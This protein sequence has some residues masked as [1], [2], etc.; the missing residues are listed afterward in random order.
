MYTCFVMSEHWGVCVCVCPCAHFLGIAQSILK[1][2][3]PQINTMSLSTGAIAP[4]CPQVCVCECVCACV[5]VWCVCFTLCIFVSKAV[6]TVCPEC[7]MLLI[8]CT[9]LCMVCLELACMIVTNLWHNPEIDPWLQLP[10]LCIL[11]L[12]V[13]VWSEG[14]VTSQSWTH[15]GHCVFI[16]RHRC[17]PTPVDARQ[18]EGPCGRSC[19]LVAVCHHTIIGSDILT[20][21]VLQD[22]YIMY[23][24]L[25]T[26]G[27][28]MIH[29]MS[30]KVG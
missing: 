29:S 19:C 14:A 9:P 30:C 7:L 16:L 27:S 17:L 12:T 13:S 5:C 6:I 15:N 24:E 20:V 18:W 26:V 4:H 3:T 8:F 28:Y 2:N 21:C 22:V 1:I 11:P 25:V 23:H 10:P